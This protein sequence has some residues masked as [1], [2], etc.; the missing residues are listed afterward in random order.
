VAADRKNG[1]RGVGCH[2][3]ISHRFAELT[4][5]S[6]ENSRIGDQLALAT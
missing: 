2:V 4:A 3:R 5:V 6:C 1:Q